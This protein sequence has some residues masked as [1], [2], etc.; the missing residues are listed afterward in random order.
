MANHAVGLFGG[1][2]AALAAAGELKSKGFPTPELMSPIPIE[3][4]EEVLGEKRSVI[5]RFTLFGGIVGGTSGFLLAAG[6]AALYAHPTGGR[7]IITIPPFLI[8]T[9]ELTILFGILF[10]VL[11]FFISS[12]LPAIR[13]RVY[14]PESAVDKFAVSVECADGSELARASDILRAA[15]AE[16]VREI[17]ES[18]A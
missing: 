6:T 4:V 16:E 14:V 12:R 13:D 11:G 15:G 1:P 17:A 5:K 9:Y 10:T 18:R 2:D 7:P 3:G 8:I